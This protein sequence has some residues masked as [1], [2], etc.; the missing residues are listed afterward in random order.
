MFPFSSWKKLLLALLIGFV[1]TMVI[2]FFGRTPSNDRT[3]SPD[4]VTLAEVTFTGDLVSIRNIRHFEYQSTSTY[5]PHYYDKTFDIATLVSVDY[6]VEPFK[7]I[8]AHTLLSF[9]FADG[10]YVSISVEIRKEQGELFSPWKG[11]ARTYELMYVIADERDVVKLRSNY[12]N[13][14]VYLYPLALSKTEMQQLFVAMLKEANTLRDHPR[15]YNTVTDNC[16]TNIIDHLNAVL[17]NRISWD[18]SFILPEKSDAYLHELGLI[19]SGMSL[20]EARAKYLINNRALEYA[21]DP[22]FSKRIRE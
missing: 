5:T 6:L 4:Q 16:T 14:L 9:G 3:W 21:N 2:V 17:P 7:D 15:F 8:G 12:R 20:E 19:A 1:V 11:I 18:H 22:E 10:S 13:D